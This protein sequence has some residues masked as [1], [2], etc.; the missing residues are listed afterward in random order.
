ML[1]KKQREWINHLSDEQTI[2]IISYDPTCEEKFKKIRS[3]IQGE[4]GKLIK[5]E[6][7]G[8]T[9]LKIS[10][11]DEI[12]IY[13]PVSPENFNNMVG[14]LTKLLGKPRSHYPLERARFVTKESGKHIDVFVINEED[15]GWINSRKFENYLKS[16]PEELK[17]YEKLKEE[18]NGLSV[19]EY[20]RRK[21][22]YINKILSMGAKMKTILGSESEDKLKIVQKAFDELDQLVEI[23]GV[24]AGSQ[25]SGQPLDKETTLQGA[26]NR[27]ENAKKL[28]SDAN[29]WIGL[30]G[31][32]HDYGEGYHLVTYAFL[33]DKSGDEFTG[34]GVEIHLPESVSEEVKKGGWFGD[35]VRI[36]AKD[37][38]ID[39]NLITREAPFIEAI[40]NAHAN[41]LK[42]KGDLVYR[43]KINAVVL[44]NEN[45]VLLLQLVNYGD[46]D[47]NTPGG[48]IE[49]G[50]TSK[51]ALLR[52]LQEELGTD[53]F[54]IVEKSKI[55]DKYD[56][57]DFVIVQQLKKGNK[58]KGQE[59]TQFII[60]FLGE[61]KEIKTQ[62]EE[63]RA[64]KW[65]DYEDL[66]S[67]LNF[68]GQWENIKEVINES[69]LKL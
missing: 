49:E 23:V 59:Q 50:E 57:P 62:E 26:R 47:W 43:K 20:Y 6:H 46:T 21:I 13:L 16:S 12:D 11:Q 33:I 48:G 66:E 31:G 3:R 64:H 52:E 54:E 24:K 53:K 37:H 55:I 34:E 9:A 7:C 58:Y 27:A 40:Q 19:R 25:I 8:A 30:E 29:C 10:G 38:K 32:L 36:Y 41:Y 69:S 45:Q 28:N 68:P 35:A 5:V 22:I 63:I 18:G 39:E 56:F 1:T 60:R 14:K 61:T 65:V 42:S 15:E 4:L 51:E 2:R 44:N 17:R 67:H